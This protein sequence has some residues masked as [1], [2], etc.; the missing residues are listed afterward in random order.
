[1][2]CGHLVVDDGVNIFPTCLRYSSAIKGTR[3]C[4]ALWTCYLGMAGGW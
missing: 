3:G 2:A 1:M 4:E